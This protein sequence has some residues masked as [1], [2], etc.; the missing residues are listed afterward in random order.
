MNNEYIVFIYFLKNNLNLFIMLKQNK[1]N[2]LCV[3]LSSLWFRDK[4]NHDHEH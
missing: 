3:T 1:E 2:T 4:I